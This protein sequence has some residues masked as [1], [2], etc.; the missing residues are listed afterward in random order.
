M[1]IYRSRAAR[2]SNRQFQPVAVDGADRSL[3]LPASS[4]GL[5]WGVSEHA[6]GSLL[7]AGSWATCVVTTHPCHHQMEVPTPALVSGMAMTVGAG[8]CTRRVALRA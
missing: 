7:V 8:L 5:G 1:S 4:R 2:A 6:C 3:A